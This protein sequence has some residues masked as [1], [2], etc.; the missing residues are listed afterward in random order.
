MG[1]EDPNQ[2]TAPSSGEATNAT[3]DAMLYLQQL[4]GTTS[5]L[6]P[7]I[8]QLIPRQVQASLA[9]EARAAQL[10]TFFT[11]AGT[12]GHTTFGLPPRGA[13]SVTVPAS[14]DRVSTSIST[15]F[16][17]PMSQRQEGTARRPL[18]Q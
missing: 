17:S 18:G 16:S 4:Y 5:A 8:P 10:A 2:G 9:V 7:V 12:S 13:Q 15:I 3:S 1:C 6:R 11:T 14:S